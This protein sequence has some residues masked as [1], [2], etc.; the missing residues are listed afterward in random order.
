MTLA[1]L[2][3]GSGCGPLIGK[4][5]EFAIGIMNGTMGGLRWGDIM[6][7]TWREILHLNKLIS[8]Y[9][10]ETAPRRG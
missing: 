7:M 5:Y 8:D 3:L 10:A 4:V 9:Q 2:G 1:V 6:E